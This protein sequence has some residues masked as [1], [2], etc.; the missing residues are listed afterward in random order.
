MS[1]VKTGELIKELKT[2]N[3]LSKSARGLKL[4]QH[5]IANLTHQVSSR[6]DQLRV[7]QIVSNFADR[8]RIAALQGDHFIEV[9][10]LSDK[11]YVVPVHASDL[12]NTYPLDPDW[13]IGVARA[14]FYEVARQCSTGLDQTARPSISLV[15]ESD[16]RGVLSRH[17]PTHLAIV[18]RW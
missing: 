2:L 15:P 3:K 4:V 5:R 10:E 6:Q 14:V 7:E 18:L 8:A 17:G 9:M 1:T 16:C 11:D 13:L 12:R